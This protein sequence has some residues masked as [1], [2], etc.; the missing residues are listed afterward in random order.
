MINCILLSCLLSILGGGIYFGVLRHY[1]S[2]LHAKYVLFGI[3]AM[4][5]LI[6]LLIPNLPNY[7]ETL[8]KAYLFDY[9]EYSAWNVVDI[10]DENLVACY[11]TAANSQEQCRCEIKQQMVVVYYQSNPYYNFLIACKQ[12]AYCLFLLMVG[13]LL[14]YLGFKCLCLLLL[15]RRFPVEKRELAGTTVYLLRATAASPHPISSFTLWRHYILLS[16]NF[17]QHFSEE[18]LHAILLHEVA[19]LQQRD[20]WQQ[21]LLELLHTLWWFNPAYYWFK[22]ELNRLNEYVADDFAVAKIGNHRFYAKLLLKAKEQQCYSKLNLA[23]YF[24]QGLF[25]QRILRLVQP[26]EFNPKANAPHRW[27]GSL[28]MIAAI[29]WNT[30]AWALPVLQTQDVAIKQYEILQQKSATTGQHEF[31][32]SCLSDELKE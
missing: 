21:I 19:H 28:I 9:N 7:S 13:G 14:L 24:A 12:P 16:E 18:E 15:A 5:W 20:T 22:G 2:A 27:A 10:E 3:I 1:L 17:E 6:P 30:S 31:C 4:S 11:E 29:F 8:E 25:K 23:V 32:K 26:Q